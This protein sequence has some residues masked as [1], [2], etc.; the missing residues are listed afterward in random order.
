MTTV[1]LFSDSFG[2]AAA[3]TLPGALQKYNIHVSDV[4]DLHEM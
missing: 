4:V 2:S 1:Y 3:V